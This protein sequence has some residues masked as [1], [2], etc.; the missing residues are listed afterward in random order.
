[1]GSDLNAFVLR[2][3]RDYQG[4]L[5]LWGLKSRQELL[6]CAEND[7]L[8]HLGQLTR[9]HYLAFDQHAKFFKGLPE[10]V[11]GLKEHCRTVLASC[12]QVEKPRFSGF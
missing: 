9:H 6:G 3:R 7:L 4:E 2:P 8:V 11:R 5:S 1:M 12:N 10:P